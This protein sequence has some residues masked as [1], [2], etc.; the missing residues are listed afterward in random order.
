M[1][2]QNTARTVSRAAHTPL[3]S[4]TTARTAKT[5]TGGTGFNSTEKSEL[6]RLGVNGLL[7]DENT[8]HE[9]GKSRDNRLVSLTTSLAISDPEWTYGFY[10]WLRGPEA[11]IRTAS[12]MGAATAVHSRVHHTDSVKYDKKM[13]DTD[14]GLNRLI[15]DAVCQRA[16]EPTELASIYLNTYGH[17]PKA[18]KRG[19]GDAAQ[20]LWNPYSVMK[21]DTA[22]HGMRFADLMN[23]AH[24]TLPDSTL[25]AHII[26]RRYGNEEGILP[27][28]VASN[29]KLRH[30]VANDNYEVLTNPAALRAAGMTWEDALSLAGP[31]VNKGQLWDA[32]ILAGMVPIFA[33]LRNLRNFSEAGISQQAKE[34]VHNQLTNEEIISK[35]R[36]LPF[37]FL[38]A[39]EAQ[40]SYEW[41]GDLESAV[42]IA[43]RNVPKL[44][45]PSI[46]I[47]DTSGSM[48]TSVSNHSKMTRSGLAAF[49]AG[50]FAAHNAD[51]VRLYIY[52]DG[53][54]R[55][56]VRKGHSVLKL[57]EEMHK[58][59][60]EVGHGTQTGP[61]LRSTVGDNPDAKRA[62][63]FTDMQSFPHGA[64][65]VESNWYSGYSRYSNS[66][67]SNRPGIGAEV[68]DSMHLY[69]FDVAGYK[70]Q[71]LQTG[72]DG[73]THQLSGM[74]GD[75]MYKWVQCIERGVE[76][77][78]PWEM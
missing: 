38:S 45:G 32:L 68:P 18:L 14:K 1:A 65:R 11:N 53:I 12:L 43:T 15:A 66:A 55:I 5:A 75:P 39:L 21:Y 69:S 44:N 36:I 33:T 23:L 41:H 13:T 49:F 51:N 9:T 72:T 62:F 31:R 61:A 17:L 64:R 6:F 42:Q 47:V 7:G 57:A 19:L 29:M 2:R 16:D 54:K 77:R 3:V 76:A 10:E 60:G 22:S 59:T 48:D 50:A 70:V 30:M 74:G 40:D 8:Y 63:I 20:R 34:Y 26:N 52:A 67:R 46:A 35:S 27:E 78:W 71:D 25:A 4:A 56:D 37:R 73:R 24:F 28:M 58:R